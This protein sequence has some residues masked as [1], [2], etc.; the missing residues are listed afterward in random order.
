[1]SGIPEVGPIGID[2]FDET[3]SLS[4][5]RDLRQKA[6]DREDGLTIEKVSQILGRTSLSPASFSSCSLEA[7]VSKGAVHSAPEIA[8][9]TITEEEAEAIAEEYK[10]LNEV[11]K[12]IEEKGATSSDLS[13]DANFLVQLREIVAR[14]LVQ[15][16]RDSEQN[17]QSIDSM[18]S[19][20]RLY[21][22]EGANLT[23]ELGKSGLKF[24][25]IAFGTLMGQFLP[26]F[27][28]ADKGVVKFFSEQVIP[29]IGNMSG[30][31]I[32]GRQK[33]ADSM[34]QLILAEY[35]AKSSKPPEANKQEFTNLLDKAFQVQT[36]AAR[37]S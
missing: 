13:S 31:T 16:S 10:K 11:A 1:M 35:N 20:Y 3:H 37:A 12:E 14:M 32:Q 5:T 27:N 24:S 8:A 9:P 15:I 18:K 36:S 23:R 17:R 22:Q 26:F 6:S 34:A 19:K 29:Q 33:I 2:E 21:T 4:W 28:D 7:R 25:L 30:S